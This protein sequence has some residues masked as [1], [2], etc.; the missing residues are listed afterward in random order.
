MQIILF[1]MSGTQN[2]KQIILVKHNQAFLKYFSYLE[3]VDPDLEL[4]REGGCS[5]DLLA[6]LAF[7]PSVTSS[8]SPK[9]RRGGQGPPGSSPRSASAIS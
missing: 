5:F 8:F 3:V 1:T 6:L 2:T 9:I 4:K 7:L